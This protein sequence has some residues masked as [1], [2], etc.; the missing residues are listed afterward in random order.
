M[1]AN[2]SG[3]AHLAGAVGTPVVAVTASATPT[4]YDLLG[5]HHQHIRAAHIDLV[6]ADTVYEAACRILNRSRSEL[7]VTR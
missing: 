3:P 1:I 2:H 6:S 4:P 7:L 5:K